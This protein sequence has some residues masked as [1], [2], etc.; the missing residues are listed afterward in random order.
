MTLITEEQ[1]LQEFLGK[2]VQVNAY[3]L[4]RLADY[5]N[6]VYVGGF[7]FADSCEELF[8][9]KRALRGLSAF[10]AHLGLEEGRFILFNNTS[11][12]DKSERLS[13]RDEG[14]QKALE[15]WDARQR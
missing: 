15:L 12:T 14:L 3:V 13:L 8:N 10:P 2:T 4:G 11:Q 6:M 7:N 5:R 1:Q 9:G